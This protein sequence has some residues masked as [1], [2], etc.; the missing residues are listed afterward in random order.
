MGKSAV[1]DEAVKLSMNNIICHEY[2][3]LFLT[4]YFV[5]ADV[6]KYFMD[7]LENDKNLSAGIGASFPYQFLSPIIV[8]NPFLS[9]RL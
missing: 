1:K 6:E 7:L 3:P 2:K 8:P 9:Q 5:V 4:K